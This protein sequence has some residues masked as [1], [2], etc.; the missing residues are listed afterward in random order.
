M[1][2]ADISLDALAKAQEKVKSLVPDAQVET[3]VSRIS[4]HS[5]FLIIQPDHIRAA[6]NFFADPALTS[7]SHLEMRRL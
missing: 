6:T 5:L 7:P 3:V 4:R 1:L 2:M